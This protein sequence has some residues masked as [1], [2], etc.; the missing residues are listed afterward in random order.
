MERLKGEGVQDW[1]SQH[2]TSP[3]HGH[4]TVASE[5]GNEIISNIHDR[6]THLGPSVQLGVLFSIISLKKAQQLQLK[7]TCQRLIDHACQDPDEWVKLVGRMLKDYPSEGTLRFNV[8]EFVDQAHMGSLLENLTHHINR[9]GIKFHPMEFA[10]LN[11]SVCKEGQGKDPK[12][13]AY[14]PLA[15]PS[16]Q[17]HFK[18][19]DSHVTIHTSRAER[20]KKMAE[21]ASPVIP[22]TAS[23]LSSGS[24]GL[25]SG[26]AGPGS[27]SASALGPGASS[28]GATTT[29]GASGI[30]GPP[31]PAKAT[32]SGLFVRKQSGGSFLRT[33][34]PR[35]MALPRN[36]SATSLP[37]RSPRVDQ[38]TTPRLIQKA[39][40]IQILDIQQGNEIMQSMNDA[41]AKLEQAEQREKELKRE[42]RAQEVEAKRAQDAE[43]KAAA[44][45]EKEEK[46]KEKEDA[47]K[48]KE[49]Q[50]QERDEQLAREKQ[51]KEQQQNLVRETRPAPD[52]DEDDDEEPAAPT[53]QPARKK[54]R[55]NSSRRG[56]L[57]DDDYD[58]V[59]LGHAAEPLSPMT[60]SLTSRYSSQSLHDDGGSIAME[61]IPAAES[62]RNAD[63]YFSPNSQQ[64]SLQQQQ[65]Q[66][67][68][69]QQPQPP[70]AGAASD[71]PTL[72]QDT[73]LLTADDRAY[74]TAFMEGHP[75]IRP[76]GNDTSY[77]IVMNQEQVQDATGK[78]MY[79][80]IL[81]EMNF[82]TGE[83]RKIK[84][85]RNRPHVPTPVFP[86]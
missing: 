28:V 16:I 77:Q 84:R 49:R 30:G 42:Q 31:R 45:R 26:P 80:L 59:Q 75:V 9:D 69:H 14:P 50:K 20:L 40:R 71:H 34:A 72:F 22:S 19:K 27:T 48:L 5:L 74:I 32:S 3:W 23:N 7:G 58:G 1:L 85:K 6:W 63:S 78:T 73:N 4:Q 70:H 82:E 17:Q 33:N 11:K 2:L 61:Y 47:K 13:K 79:E 51:E 67:Q 12:T 66:V 44:L 35:P 41:K 29:S 54:S 43:K 55:T 21:Q 56:S 62:N 83:W 24:T 53:T 36:P 68:Q 52:D 18:L 57:D 81:I 10:F 38:P 64:Q 65:Q 15:G 8:E 25:S 46:K 76:N 37:L 60:P 86:A 39:S